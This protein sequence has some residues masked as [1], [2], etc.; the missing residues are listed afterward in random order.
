MVDVD[1]CQWRK[2]A[3]KGEVAA[4]SYSY[5]N[6]DNHD[7]KD[8]GIVEC[9]N[10]RNEK[11]AVGRFFQKSENLLKTMVGR[12]QGSSLSKDWRA[13]ALWHLS[14]PALNADDDFDDFETVLWE[15]FS[16]RLKHLAAPQNHSKSVPNVFPPLTNALFANFATNYVL[17]LGNLSV[18]SLG[19]RC[20]S[21][22]RNLTFFKPWNYYQ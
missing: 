17:N 12:Q 18:R 9:G 22:Q 21:S 14:V 2:P 15:P 10:Q 6:Q 4:S 8:K 20:I 3:R 7:D 19:Q 13:A 16:P 5:S 1:G 11:Y